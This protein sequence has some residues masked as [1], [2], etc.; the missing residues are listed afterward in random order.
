M[1]PHVPRGVTGTP[2]D[3]IASVGA[4]SSS[5]RGKLFLKHGLLTA[6]D[7]MCVA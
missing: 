5:T 1:L 3:I 6:D 4:R 2:E 7:A